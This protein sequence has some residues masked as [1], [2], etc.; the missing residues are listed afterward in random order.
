MVLLSNRRLILAETESTYG[1]DP[2]PGSADAILVRDLNLVPVQS[3]VVGRDVVRPYLGS[4]E[5]LL[6]NT[7]VEC[8]FSVDL[9]GSGSASTAPRFSPVL[10]ACGLAETYNSSPLTGTATAG[11]LN[12]ITLDGTASSTDNAYTNLFLRITAGTGSG[13]IGIITSYTGSTK[14]ATF[15]AL[16]GAVTP[17]N[18]SAYTIDNQYTYTPSNT[19]FSSVTIHYNIDGVL[20][21]LTGCRGTLVVNAA[22]GQIPSI[23]F[24]LTGVYNPPT[25]T[26]LPAA[27]YAN[28]AAPQIFKAGSSGAFSL[29]DYAACVQTI[30]VDLGNS[31]LYRELI[32]CTKEVRIVDRVT[33]GSTTIEAT[34]IAAKDYFTAA[35]SDNTLGTLTFMHGTAAG[36]LVGFT[37][38]YTDIGD[39]SYGDTDGIQML[40]IPFTCI[41]PA[42][43]A[44]A[45]GGTDDSLLLDDYLFT[46][47]FPLTF[48][49][50]TGGGGTAALSECCLTFG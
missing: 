45:G 14:V 4:T 35:L 42:P 41:P 13:T 7:R 2:S 20:H 32:G 49:E 34:T 26:A 31:V 19:T 21:R 25:D 39:V 36:N 16:S 23:D 17:N 11:A 3:D 6:A 40:T 24:T 8:T 50:T 9:T 37:S 46:D 18:T 29:L 27:T 22:V 5:Q 28:Q 44:G 1:V 47:L 30:S 15:R 43:T 12:S 48:A 33:T 38:L 10:K